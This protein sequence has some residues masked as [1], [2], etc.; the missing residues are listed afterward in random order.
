VDVTDRPYPLL[1]ESVA[2]TSRRLYQI[3]SGEIMPFHQAP[4]R[5]RGHHA[6]PDA[7]NIPLQEALKDEISNDQVT[8]KLYLPDPEQG[9]YRATRFDWSGIIYSL[10]HEGHQYFGE[11]KLTHD[12]MFHEDLAGPVESF[13]GEGTGFEEAAPGGEFVRI[14]VGVLEKES[15]TVYR[16]NHTYRILDHGTWKV[17]TGV[18][19]IEFSHAVESETGWGYLYTKR[20]SLKEEE[21]GFVI[22]HRLEN[23]GQK[24]I[25]TDQYNHNFFMIDGQTTGPDFR[26]EFPFQ[27]TSA[28]GLRDANQVLRLEGNRVNFNKRFTPGGSAWVELFGYGSGPDDHQFRVFNEKTGAGV[29]VKVDRPVHRMTF[30]A[31]HSTLCPENFIYLK[32]EPGE[33]EQWRSDYT[34]FTL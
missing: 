21:P 29:L 27:I 11:W 22:D 32:I 24:P 33:E 15:D 20:I 30:W 25:E 28:E 3:H 6:L 34:L 12:P 18:G 7:W 8:M 2:E 16:W 14:G 17:T 26:V 13:R 31:T 10:E 23:T 4:E 5:A 19:W 1:V 9:F